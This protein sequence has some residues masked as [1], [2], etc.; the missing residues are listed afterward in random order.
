[1]TAI[2]S[3]NLVR[4][5]DSIAET[6]LV[7]MIRQEP[8]E[9]QMTNKLE[10]RS[11]F[12]DLDYLVF[13]TLSLPSGDHLG[14]IRHE[15]SPA[16]GV[17]ICVRHNQPNIPAVLQAAIAE[18]NLTIE[19]FTWIH[20]EYE[21]QLTFSVVR[22]SEIESNALSET[23][24]Q[25]L[26]LKN[27]KKVHRIERN[28]NSSMTKRKNQHVVPHEQGWAVKSEGSERATQVFS[29][30]QEAANRAREIAK[31][32]QSEMFIHNK[33]GKIRERNTYGKD[34]NPPKG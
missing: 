34:P 9:I 32:Q 2:N 1:M 20:P 12:D 22:K 31:N 13:A 4:L 27:P 19:D 10:F 33:Q 21:Q 17:E 26:T 25:P 18:M 6:N 15:N 30:Q 7:A 5:E 3:Q 28:R 8:A 16:P 23:D 14:L 29:T 24:S 11:S